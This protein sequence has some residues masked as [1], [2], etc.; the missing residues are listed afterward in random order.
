MIANGLTTALAGAGGGMALTPLGENVGVMAGTKV[1]STAAYVAA[2]IGAILLSFSP[3]V[4]ALVQTLPTGVIGGLALVLFGLVAMVGVRLWLDS[5]VDL[6]DPV[7]MMVAGAAIVAG[8]GNLTI[9]IG[10]LKLDG[11]V[12]GSALIVLG[13]PLLRALRALREQRRLADRATDPGKPKLA[14]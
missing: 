5:G 14:P 12:W 9:G 2:A 8:A 10:W 7:T 3:K 6:A 1:Y 13:H 4:A 11:V